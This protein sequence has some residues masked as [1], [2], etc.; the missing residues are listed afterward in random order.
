MRNHV[1]ISKSSNILLR[2]LIINCIHYPNHTKYQQSKGA[3]SDTKPKLPQKKPSHLDKNLGYP[4][5]L[6][7]GT[8]NQ[9]E[10]KINEGYALAISF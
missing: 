8:Y 7:Q 5:G 10:I 1:K 9:N 6:T 2:Y 3:T 4:V